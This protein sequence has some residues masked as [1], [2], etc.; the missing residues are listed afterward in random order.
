M[1][2]GDTDYV[3]PPSFIK[4]AFAGAA[5]AAPVAVSLAAAARSEIEIDLPRIE[6]DALFDDAARE[7]KGRDA[8]AEA[9]EAQAAAME[10]ARRPDLLQTFAAAT[11]FRAGSERD[12]KPQEIKPQGTLLQAM[13]VKVEAPLQNVSAMQRTGELGV[14][15][16]AQNTQILH[17]GTESIAQQR[18]MVRGAVYD[19]KIAAVNVYRDFAQQQGVDVKDILPA[20]TLLSGSPGEGVR[21]LPSVSAREASGAG[22]MATASPTGGASAGLPVGPNGKYDRKAIAEMIDT[23]LRGEASQPVDTRASAAAPYDQKAST[24]LDLDNPN[25]DENYKSSNGYKS[26][27]SA[28]ENGHSIAE[29][30]EADP[31]Q[32][33]EM[34]MLAQV[35]ADI[36]AVHE[37]YA[38]LTNKAGE[39]KVSASAIEA[40]RENGSLQLPVASPE[41]E[42][43]VALAGGSMQGISIK[44]QDAGKLG[45]MQMDGATMRLGADVGAARDLL[46][47]LE[48][49]PPMAAIR[50][51]A[52]MS[53][54]L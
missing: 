3:P 5:D 15:D 9:A 17:R 12:M 40:A 51:S 37:N 10:A 38:E 53:A 23:K 4:R 50:P 7:A 6:A 1:A 44:I 35:E 33:P 19:A 31:E 8:E 34:K 42:A 28:A 16:I 49:P 11:G 47:K 45:A 14:K 25:P 46:P 30:L 24:A 26:L 20:G 39:Y 41:L 52:G 29:V 48:V 36:E 32:L 22:S 21:P 43:D 27:L 18:E 54:S 13:G 2:F